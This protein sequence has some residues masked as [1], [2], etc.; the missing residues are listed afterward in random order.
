MDVWPHLLRVIDVYGPHRC[1]WG[2][3]ITWGAQGLALEPLYSEAVT[4]MNE[5][6]ASLDET[7]KGLVMGGAI[8]DWLRWKA[9]D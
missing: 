5:A 6:L 7:D 3:D 1:F 2:S 8:H 9:S 4:M